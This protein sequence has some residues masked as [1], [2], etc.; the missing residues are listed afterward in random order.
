MT[1][2]FCQLGFTGKK[3]QVEKTFSTQQAS[4][5][6]KSESLPQKFIAFYTIF[7]LTEKEGKK[8]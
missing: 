1:R 7:F 8:I 6:S 2:F 3:Q 4:E 5:T